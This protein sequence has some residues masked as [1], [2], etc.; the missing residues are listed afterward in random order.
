MEAAKKA[1]SPQA[2]ADFVRDAI[3]QHLASEAY[4]E[5][6]TSRRYYNGENVTISER[7]NLIIDEAGNKYKDEWTPN[8]RLK[9]G[10]YRMAVNQRTS[11]L[12]AN[13]AVFGNPDTKDKLGTAQNPFDTQIFIA[14]EEAHVGG[15]SYT[16]FNNDHLEIFR[17]E[18]FMELLDYKNGKMRAGIRH[19]RLADDTPLTAYLFEEDGYTEFSEDRD[20]LFRQVPAGKLPYR[21][22]VIRSQVSVEI[23]EGTPYPGF[24]IIPLRCNRNGKPLL[25]GRR[26]TIDALDTAR[27]VGVNNVDSDF[28]YWLLEGFGG[29]N[30]FDKIKALAEL[31]QSH[32]LVTPPA[33]SNA[34]ITPHNVQAPFEGTQRTIE[35][36]K[37]QLNFDFGVF[38]PQSLIASSDTATA[39]QAAYEMINTETNVF[40]LEHL[41]PYVSQILALADIKDKFKF[42][43]DP[44]TNRRENM[45]TLLL[46]APYLDEQYIREIGMTILGDAD[47]IE[48]VSKRVASAAAERL[49]NAT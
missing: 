15:T 38:N 14:A 2:L 9:S 34:R 16:F 24:P 31:R 7:Q 33:D 1:N 49:A 4:L 44:V 39:I 19:W 22:T 8:H 46:L 17:F 37:E 47:R 45:E 36:L 43:R 25:Y 20:G 28:V 21:Q 18:N 26:D 32:A 6:Q 27:S 29:M 10:F 11:Y 42:E 23:A 30:N 48:E 13:G 3:A 5:A 40:E 12:C 35:E 41:N